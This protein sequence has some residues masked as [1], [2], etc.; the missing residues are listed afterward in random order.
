MRWNKYVHC[1][2]DGRGG[3]RGWSEVRKRGVEKRR[4]GREGEDEE[5]GWT[6]S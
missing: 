1:G 6:V 3:G 5:V 4:G 2:S